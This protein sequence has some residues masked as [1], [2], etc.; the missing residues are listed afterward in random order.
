MSKYTIDHANILDWVKAHEGDKFHACMC[1]A[2][3]EQKFMGKNW[4]GSGVS[5]QAETWAGIAEHLHP[6]AF[7]FVFAGTLND[8]LIS[9]AMREAGLRKYH[10]AGAWCYIQGF[11]KA[12]RIS[13]QV[14]RAAGAKRTVIG[15]RKHAPKFDAVKHGYREKDNG[16]NSRT[17]ETFEVTASTTD[18]ARAWD[19]H[20]YGGQMLKPALESILIFQ[21]PYEGKAVPCITRTGAGALNID[22]GRIGNEEMI[23]R[24]NKPEQNGS[25]NASGGIGD[26]GVGRWPANLSLSHH[27]DCNGHCA[28]SCPVLRLGEQSGESSSPPIGSMGGGSNR[29]QLYGKFAGERHENGYGD[30]GTAARVFFNSDFMYERLENADLLTYT[31]KP[32]TTEREAGLAD[33]EPQTVDDGRLTPIDNAYQR[34]ETERRN[35]HTT[36]K[37]ISLLRHWATLLLPPPMY[38]PRRLLVPFAGVS[39]EMIGAMLAGWEDV[40]GIELEAEHIPIARARLAYWQQ[41]R[42]KLMNPDA[43]VK[44]TVSKTPEG[45]SDMFT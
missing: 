3:Y 32:S 1:D 44:V 5:F 28:P 11:P 27:P 17:R 9:V 42:Y 39:S 43:P 19:G 7:L 2:P 8:D 25:F 31:P 20:R 37:P 21:K 14:D 26:G 16:F 23:P 15:T 30:S 29:K 12:T 40:Q 38:G 36:V 4:D 45:Q 33:F 6:G 18:L 35:I 22:G 34:G 10:R 41:M 24:N 13:P